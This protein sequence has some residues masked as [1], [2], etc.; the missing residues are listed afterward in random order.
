MIRGVAGSTFERSAQSMKRVLRLTQRRRALDRAALNSSP[1]SRRL[2]IRGP[3]DAPALL[4]E[5]EIDLGGAKA[6]ALAGLITCIL[7]APET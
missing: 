5:N 4:G 1:S 2:P 3:T 7:M 6:S